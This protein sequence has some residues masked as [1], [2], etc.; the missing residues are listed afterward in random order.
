M[1]SIAINNSTIFKNFRIKIFNQ[2]INYNPLKK[3][4]LP[5]L[6]Q[7]KQDLFELKEGM[8]EVLSYS[9]PIYSG[10]IKQAIRDKRFSMFSVEYRAY[11]FEGYDTQFPNK[12]VCIDSKGDRRLKPHLYLQYVEV[13]PQFARQG[14][15]K[16]AVKELITLSE[17]EGC[18]GRI[19]LDAHKVESP[20]MTK[21]PSPSLAHWKC[22]FRFVNE[23]DNKTMQKVLNGELPLE[24][25]PEGSMYYSLI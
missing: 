10:K 15:Y 9:P 3:F 25:A 5:K 11:N 23:N 16:N 14:A 6:S 2:I 21:I 20:D 13:K 7:L 8:P 22:G 24:D 1:N 4:N 12:Y 17:L 19:I 18:E